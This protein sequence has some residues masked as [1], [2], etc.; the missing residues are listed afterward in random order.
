M[1]RKI[2]T[3]FVLIFMS[4]L[5]SMPVY[6]E[7]MLVDKFDLCGGSR[8]HSWEEDRE[9]LQAELMNKRN[10]TRKY[11]KEEAE[12]DF[13]Y[14]ALVC[15]TYNKPYRV[16]KE[17]EDMFM[18]NVSAKFKIQR[19][20][21]FLYEERLKAMKK[22]MGVSSVDNQE[23]LV[24]FSGFNYKLDTLPFN[25]LAFSDARD[26]GVCVGMVYYEALN[27]LQPEALKVMD[28][29][30]LTRK[31]S[32]FDKEYGPLL[33]VETEI[34]AADEAFEGRL[35]KYEPMDIKLRTNV[36]TNA[37]QDWE[38]SVAPTKEKVALS[39]L[40]SSKPDENMVKSIYWLWGW[41]NLICNE[42][43]D[44]LTEEGHFDGNLPVIT[45]DMLDVMKEELEAGRPLSIIIGRVGG[46]RHSIL[47]YKLTQDVKDP[48]I[49]YL[50]V[51][52][53][54]YPANYYNGRESKFRIVFCKGTYKGE[55]ALY[56]MYGPNM[57]ASGSSLAQ[58]TRDL[59]ISDS[60]G[61]MLN[62]STSLGSW[63]AELTTYTEG[64]SNK[65][66]LNVSLPAINSLKGEYFAPNYFDIELKTR[67]GNYVRDIL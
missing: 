4:L 66:S 64:A 11:K 45:G 67:K 34:V 52:D 9:I 37:M 1:K 6:A 60:F 20:E 36:V 29:S 17:F 21:K 56:Y 63:G 53:S 8:F 43:V 41:G 3:L 47:G 13:E 65:L 57:L 12:H 10:Y 30:F 44:L 51:A 2:I 28:F 16:Y 14:I 25:N 35:Y 49:Y 22:I 42:Q 27:Y 40:E 61:V 31:I 48:D 46:S 24:A 55:E 23:E 7:E 19:Y 18:S 54:N 5:F 58:Y 59:V 50:H 62:R 39:E 26:G 32:R 38:E 33:D 15:L